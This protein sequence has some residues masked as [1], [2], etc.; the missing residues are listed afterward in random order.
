MKCDGKKHDVD[1]MDKIANAFIDKLPAIICPIVGSTK[2]E[3][4]Q[5]TINAQS[6]ELSRKD[7]FKILE[8]SQGGRCC[9]ES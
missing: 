7:W 6:I 2:I 8:V 1:S 5:S 9:E 3:R 4:I